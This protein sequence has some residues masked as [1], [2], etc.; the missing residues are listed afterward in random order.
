MEIL[1]YHKNNKIWYSEYPDKK[2]ID[3]PFDKPFI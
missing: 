2:L 1:T 3:F